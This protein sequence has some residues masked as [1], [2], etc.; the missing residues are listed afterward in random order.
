MHLHQNERTA[1]S[2]ELKALPSSPA[3][4]ERRKSVSQLCSVCRLCVQQRRCCCTDWVRQKDER[5]LGENLYSVSKF[6]P[7]CVVLLMPPTQFGSWPRPFF[8]LCHRSEIL[9][10]TRTAL[11]WWKA[12]YL[13]MMLSRRGCFPPGYI[14]VGESIRRVNIKNLNGL[15]PWYNTIKTVIIKLV[16]G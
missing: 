1:Q 13:L 10:E 11:L 12:F 2:D 8:V 5:K 4:L 15:K 16:E 3:C 6:P 9:L 14:V 7:W